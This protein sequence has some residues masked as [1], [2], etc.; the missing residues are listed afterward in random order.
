MHSAILNVILNLS[1]HLYWLLFH[2][3]G[4]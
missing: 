2:F 4:K 3:I 1:I